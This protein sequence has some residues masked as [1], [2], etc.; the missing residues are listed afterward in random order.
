M[1]P[2]SEEIDKNQFLAICRKVE[3]GV[4]L[5]LSCGRSFL[6]HHFMVHLFNRH[7]LSYLISAQTAF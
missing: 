1:H 5:T 7:Q 2:K 3:C 6:L 4:V